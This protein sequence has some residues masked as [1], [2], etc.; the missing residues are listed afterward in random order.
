MKTVRNMINKNLKMILIIA[1]VTVVALGILLLLISGNEER[2]QVPTDPTEAAETIETETEQQ[3]EEETT[4]EPGISKEAQALFDAKVESMEDSAAVAQ[5]LETIDLKKNIASYL[6]SL[7]AKEEPKT[8]IITFDKT[9]AEVDKDTFD[10][11][12][13]RYAEQILALV[14]D[15]DEVQWTYSVKHNNG[16]K[17]EVTVFLDTKQATELLKNNIK[18]YGESSK[19]VQALL[20]QQKGQ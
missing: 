9:V 17:E 7:Q 6:V 1:V 4:P 10:K 15:A 3:T 11:K 13:Q 12:V 16:K 2:D 5:L 20:N 14:S 8:L 19:M 18:E